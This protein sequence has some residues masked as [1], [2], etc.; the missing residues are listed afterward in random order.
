VLGGR[1]SALC[2]AL[3][4]LVVGPGWTAAADPTLGGTPAPGGERLLEASQQAPTTLLGSVR[5]PTRV[6]AHGW[7]AHLR[8][9]RVLVGDV[10]AGS[11]LR[12]AWEEL[13]RGRPARF[14][15]GD[16]V[17]VALDP[18]PGASLWR[19]RFPG[20]D[21][22]VVAARGE[23]FLLDPSAASTEGLA[24]LLALLPGERDREAG[25]A[26]RAR[27]VAKAQPELARAAL[28]ELGAVPHLGRRLTPEALGLLAGA[29]G[30][31][32]RPQDLREALLGMVGRRRLVSL[33][34]LAVT[35]S[36]EG[37]ALRASALAALAAL[38]GGLPPEQLEVFLESDDPGVRAVA[39]WNAAGTPWERR[40]P[41]LLRT[42]PAPEVRAAVVE[43]LLEARGEASIGTVSGALFDRD[44]EVREAAVRG[45]SG[46]GPAA[47]PTLENLVERRQGDEVTTPLAALA[48]AGPS[49]RMALE[50]IASL[51]RDED[52]RALARAMMGREPRPH[53]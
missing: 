24:A 3:V 20:G 35:W 6:D 31:P 38:D 17:L 36:Q 7:A 19:Q 48:M 23:A 22:R 29:V 51:H 18:L 5:Q 1:A 44:T 30:D 28:E 16:R 8:V 37:S 50:R 39:V 49:G 11:T 26:A 43:T 42:D 46:L 47:V 4:L 9:E 13:A 32:G 2:L 40:L 52:V 12:M 14:R 15:D 27:L 41:G 53:H 45:L 21:V 34:E 25:V 33:R 10:A